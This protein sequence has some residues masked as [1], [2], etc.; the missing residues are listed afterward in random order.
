[1]TGGIAG[2]VPARVA[3]SNSYSMK[4]DILF[5]AATHGDEQ[6]G[7]N[8][9]KELT[10]ASSFDWMIGNVPAQKK[11]VRYTQTDLNRAAPGD[12]N[13]PVYETRRAA[14]LIECSK[15]YRYT[16]D[17]HGAKNDCGM[18]LIV[19]KISKENLRL[20]SY[21]D[22]D[23]IVLWPSV[24]PEM[25]YPPSEF[26]PCG[27]EIECGNKYAKETEVSL[28]ESI[29]SF[30]SSYKEKEMLSDEEVLRI[31]ADKQVYKMYGSLSPSTGVTA[32]SL[33][34]F[35]EITCNDEVFTPVFI[36]TYEEYS[37]VLCYKLA[38]VSDTDLKNIFE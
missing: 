13:S 11:N 9:L 16:I 21:F 31:L 37:D 18:F 14:E 26:F 27:L 23:R 28:R 7:V 12:I 1:M 35:E 19:T 3:L 22:I 32:S 29:T 6:V 34:E 15:Q 30:L 2:A 8:A 17:L 24:T 38:T 33:S 20:A 10:S 25:Q 4:K 36:N 5:I